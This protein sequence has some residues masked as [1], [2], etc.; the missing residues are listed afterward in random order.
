[1]K[2]LNVAIFFGGQSSEHA[3]SLESGKN[4]ALALNLEKY[5][6]TLVGIS[7]KGVM[8]LLESIDE[9]A[10][11]DV[12][13]PIDLSLCGPQVLL[14][15]SENGGANVVDAKSGEVLTKIDLAFPV[16][17]GPFGEDGTIQGL[18]KFLG[19]PFVGASV[20]GSA[21]GMDKAVTKIMLQDAKIAI[22][23]F[24]V[25]KRH[26]QTQSRYDDLVRDLGSPFFIKPANMG[27]SVGVFKIK[28]KSDFDE[29]LKT[30]FLYD[31]RVLAEEYIDAREIECAVLGNDR[32]GEI[33]TS[34]PGE[35]I[36]KH[37]FYSY[38]AKYLDAN[39]AD[40]KIPAELNE[41]QVAEVRAI[42]IKAF[43]ALRCEGLARV[44]FFLRKS[45]QKL[46][47]NE[48]NTL[49]G[50][51][52]ISMYP[53]MMAAAGIPY[54]ELIDR[55]ILLAMKRHEEDSLLKTN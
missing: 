34:L 8:H 24:I 53:K 36:P 22:G 43:C 51:T 40:L 25:I 26:E 55:L 16:L 14:S 10:K 27:S 45:D 37:E 31:T 29:K 41:K 7:Q 21:V 52:K 35:I 4:V 48:I 49:P 3:V 32:G 13:K 44:D 38:E 9:L 23:K 11:T 39:G 50:F 54:T 47:L 46:F 28:S 19:L 1:M 18:L 17:H 20:L 6:R 30:A 42:S 15:P 12:A 33:L 5:Q 2:K